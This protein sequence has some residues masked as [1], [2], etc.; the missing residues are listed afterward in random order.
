MLICGSAVGFSVYMYVCVCVC[1]CVCEFQKTQDEVGCSSVLLFFGVYCDAVGISVGVW[2]RERESFRWHKMRHQW[3]GFSV[4]YCGAVGIIVCVCACMLYVCVCVCH[5]AC[6][7]ESTRKSITSDVMFQYLSIYHNG[8]GINACVCMCA[9]FRPHKMRQQCCG[10]RRSSPQWTTPTATPRRVL[11]VSI[12][13]KF[14][15]NCP[16]VYHQG[17]DHHPSAVWVWQQ[18]SAACVSW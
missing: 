1:V 6:V 10:W 11:D 17:I 4:V 13:S 7:W 16:L 14:A 3:C 8:M 12:S 9:T 15:V 2:E 18:T 5:C